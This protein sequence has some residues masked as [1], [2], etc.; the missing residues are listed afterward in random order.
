[1]KDSRT[2]WFIDKPVCEGRALV[3]KTTK[4]VRGIRDIVRWLIPN[5]NGCLP[6]DRHA[7]IIDEKHEVGTHIG[8]LETRRLLWVG[9][10]V[11]ADDDK[12]TVTL[13]CRLFETEA[14]P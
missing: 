4:G 7:L 1:M 2:V 10:I 12:V 6:I 14:T 8:C 3:I 13:D 11:D 9:E 5:P